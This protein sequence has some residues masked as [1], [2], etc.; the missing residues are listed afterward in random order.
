MVTLKMRLVSASGSPLQRSSRL[1][2]RA[3]WGGRGGPNRE[4]RDDQLLQAGPAVV[5]G[6]ITARS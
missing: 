4:H 2:S 5:K 3:T 6:E 1:P